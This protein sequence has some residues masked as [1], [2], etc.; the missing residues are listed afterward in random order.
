MRNF[1]SPTLRIRNQ[2]N[3]QQVFKQRK[4][5]FSSL[6]MLY[7]RPNQLA[8]ARLGVIVSKKN[9]RFAVARNRL[10]RQARNTFRLQQRELAGFD[11]V[12]IAN[13]AAAKATN[14]EL[15]ECLQELFERLIK[16]QQKH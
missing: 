9:A 6:Y 13:K 12:V 2:E 14:N 3:Y 11:L 8:H 16:Q 1:F 4:R 5:L 15:R 7:Y 10:K